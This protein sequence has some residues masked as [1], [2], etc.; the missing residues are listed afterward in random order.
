MHAV[1]TQER[2]R[3]SPFAAVTTWANQNGS[4]R[5]APACTKAKGNRDALLR[6]VDMTKPPRTTPTLAS[7]DAWTVGPDRR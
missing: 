5:P 2:P 7:R 3:P 6:G 4:A 1:G